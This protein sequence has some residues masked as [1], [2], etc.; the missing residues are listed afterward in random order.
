MRLYGRALNAF[1]ARPRVSAFAVTRSP[2]HRA[3][4]SAFC[5]ATSIVH[6]HMISDLIYLRTV[7]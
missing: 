1:D 3:S 6:P 5:F 7:P 2:P 4:E